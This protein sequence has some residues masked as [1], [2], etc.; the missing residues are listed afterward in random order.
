MPACDPLQA[1]L[2]FRRRH[3]DLHPVLIRV[4]ACFPTRFAWLFH[5]SNKGHPAHSHYGNIQPTVSTGR[6]RHLQACSVSDPVETLAGCS[7]LRTFGAGG[8]HQSFGCSALPFYRALRYGK[9]ANRKS[10]DEGNGQEKHL[11]ELHCPTYSFRGF[12]LILSRSS[13][14]ALKE[15]LNSFFNS[16]NAPS[17]VSALTMCRDK[18]SSYPCRVLH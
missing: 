3:N 13:F 14:Y 18:A 2:C 6:I 15:F 7:F 8:I 10:Q 1:S 9:G 12:V 16:R 11:S 17:N 5:L 4:C